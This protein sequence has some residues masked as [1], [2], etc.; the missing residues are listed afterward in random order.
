MSAMDLDQPSSTSSP[1]KPLKRA[2]VTYGRRREHQP[3]VRDSSVT[4][5]DCSS[6]AVQSESL[7]G[8]ES[9]SANFLAFDAQ[10]SSQSSSMTYANDDGMDDASPTKPSHQFSWRA[11]LKALDE[12]FDNDEELL[13]QPRVAE[14]SSSSPLPIQPPPFE[15][16]E[17]THKD[18]TPPSPAPQHDELFGDTLLHPT[19]EL[20]APTSSAEDSPIVSRRVRRSRKRVDSDSE[21]ENSGNSSSVSPVHHPI[22]TPLRRSPPTPSTSEFEMPSVRQK[23]D[24]GKGKAP[25]RN[26]PP[27]RFESESVSTNATS[28]KG[29]KARH[30]D[31]SVRSKT[32]APTKKD[33][34]ETVLESSRIIASKNVEVA[35]TEQQKHTKTWLF[36]RIKDDALLPQLKQPEPPSDPISNFSSPP[37]PLVG[38]GA[39]KV[40]QNAYSF[41]AP[42]CLLVPSATV[43][44][45]RAPVRNIA[46]RASPQL[47][48]AA[49]DSTDDEMPSVT[50]LLRQEEAKRT[51]ADYK[52]EIAELKQRALQD[53]ARRAAVA[54]DSDD[55][56]EIVDDMHVT[57]REEAAKR[58]SDKLLHVT[59]SKAKTRQ[60]ALARKSLPGS[61]GSRTNPF[62]QR[63]LTEYLKKS[64]MSSFDRKVRGKDTTAPLTT[65]QLSVAL[66]RQAE[67][68]KL[69]F[70]RQREQEWRQRGGRAF[71]EPVEAGENISFKDSLEAYV[72]KGLEAAERDV[73]NFGSMEAYDTDEDDEDYAPEERGSV[74]PEPTHTDG[75]SGSDQENQ[76]TSLDV[77][78][79]AGQQTEAE[80]EEYQVRRR[81]IRHPRMVTSDDEDDAPRILVPNSS[82]LDLESISNAVVTR[83][84][85][86]D[87]TED[88]NDKENSQML[89]YDRS[90]DKENKAVVR[91]SPSAA[92]PPLGSRPGSLLDI[93][94]GVHGRL[95][96]SSSLGGFDAAS[97]SPKQNLRSPLKDIAEEED[98]FLSSQSPFTARLLQSTSKHPASPPRASTSQ[99]SLDSPP[100]LRS[101]QLSRLGSSF[102]DIENEKN[103]VT[104]FGS[105]ALLPSFSETL[106]QCSPGSFVPLDPLANRGG[107][108]QF[109]SDEHDEGLSFKKPA[110]LGDG[111]DLSLSLDVGLKPALEVSSTLRRKA[112]NIFEKEQKYVIEMANRQQKQD[113]NPELY[114]SEN[115]FLTQTRPAGPD[116]EQYCRKSLQTPQLLASQSLLGDMIPW[117]SERAPLR[118]LSFTAT[119]E[120]PDVR[121][122]RRLRRRSTSPLDGKTTVQD[123]GSLLPLLISPLPKMNAFDVL[124]KQS[125][126]NAPKRKLEKSEFVAAEAVESDEDE[127]VGFGPINKDDEEEADEADDEKVLE[128]LV[129]D[130]VM[131][132]ETERPDLVQEKFREHEEEDDKKVEKL[133]QDAIQGK[134]RV[135]RRDRGIGFDDDSDNDE[136]DEHNRRIRRGMNKKRKI[137]GRNEE[138]KAFYEAYQRDLI[139]DDVEFVHLQ[140]DTQMSGVDEDEDEETRKVVSTEAL[141]DEIRKAVRNKETF[142]TLD[143]ED[144]SWIDRAEEENDNIVPV[145]VMTER[146]R[147]TYAKGPALSQTDFGPERPNRTMENDQEKIKLRSWARGQGSGNQGTGR[148]AVGAAITGHAKAK[149]KTGGGSLRTGQAA[150]SKSTLTES[151]KLEKGP[152][153]LS[154]VSDRSSRFV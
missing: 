146:S 75:E 137:D 41:G 18:T 11:Q 39:N 88:E 139:D 12:A 117:S 107:F 150:G 119:Q 43:T 152:S 74:S 58:K 89:M 96:P 90:E 151:R 93:E 109:F 111:D 52:R 127:L 51:E 97:N 59:P 36:D 17:S 95:S 22:N 71:E 112:D 124:G 6:P 106:S 40:D 47:R 25:A 60:L 149:V 123:N 114:I 69:K 103:V 1:V 31:D 27:L 126:S 23:A 64:A 20:S 80:D 50:D 26:V 62:V 63:N 134:L 129:D 66:M 76:P 19:S 143:P 9:D 8:K 45:V 128:G 32:K 87:Q 130:A 68:E 104:G 78:D 94:D 98:P 34:R 138:T 33:L 91:H 147:K 154:V 35:R 101:V 102:S 153:M 131:D 37:V 145:K 115:G 116:A 46:R 13:A 29:N 108:S 38:H 61:S 65:Q 113:K 120:S 85:E 121:P 84:S 49:S 81:G 56:L 55:D 86:S 21:R 148:S 144:I 142:G 83:N 48:P 44:Q 5:A 57:A 125:K 72:Q 105:R 122:L 135:K 10:Q 136:E 54:E 15:E 110:L 92:R 141:K 30:K 4:L 118:T 70:I 28:K 3:E 53:A 79:D 133:H 24:K 7:D 99:M 42:S 2:A 82:V 132:I 100:T 73:A 77:N 140:A 16:N 14:R 67:T